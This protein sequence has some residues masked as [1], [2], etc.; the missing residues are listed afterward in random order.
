[1]TK[2]RKP[3]Y[4]GSEERIEKAKGRILTKFVDKLLT[5]ILPKLFYDVKYL[6]ESKILQ[7]EVPYQYFY[8]ISEM[9]EIGLKKSEGFTLNVLIR[10]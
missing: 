6:T 4:K 10:L 9:L 7:V 3:I 8:K 2:T 1:L 5:G